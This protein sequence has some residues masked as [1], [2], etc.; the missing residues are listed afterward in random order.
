MDWKVIFAEICAQG[1]GGCIA[2]INFA[3]LPAE[4]IK[5]YKNKS[6]KGVFT[7]LMIFSIGATIFGFPH[8]YFIGDPY[9]FYPE[10]LGFFFCIILI[11]QGIFYAHVNRNR[12]NEP[13][14]Q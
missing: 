13:P 7:P 11:S 1:M 2:L 12:L 4:I 3:G 14:E 8:G 6:T 9:L 5:I 10:M